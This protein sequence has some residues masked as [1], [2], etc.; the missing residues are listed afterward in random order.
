MAQARQSA[1]RPGDASRG[2]RMAKRVAYLWSRR[3]PSLRVLA[4][5]NGGAKKGAAMG[6]CSASNQ[7]DHPDVPRYQPLLT[8]ELGLPTRGATQGRV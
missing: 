3:R 6:H 4:E 8:C 7:D 1:S 5:F 2:A